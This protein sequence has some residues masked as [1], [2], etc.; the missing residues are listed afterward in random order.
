M[1]ILALSNMYPPHHIGGY[2]LSCRD[3]MD[4]LRARGH[5]ITVLTTDMRISGVADPP[6]ERA[7]GI[8]RELRF[9]WEDHRLVSPSLR[10]RLMIERSNQTALR[11][12]LEEANPDVVSVWNMGDRKSVV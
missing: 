6:D 2:E 10:R 1:R 11:S 3:V 8:R 9:Y 5:E 7:G 12:A 4:R